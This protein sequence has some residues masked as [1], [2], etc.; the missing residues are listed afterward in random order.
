[1]ATKL[2]LKSQ[3]YQVKEDFS[4]SVDVLVNHGIPNFS[5]VFS[6]NVPEKLRELKTFSLVSVP[7]RNKNVFGIVLSRRSSTDSSLKSIAKVIY[8]SAVLTQEQMNLLHACMNR[9]G[10]FE[11]GR[12]HV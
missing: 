8:P 1:M 11:I 5:N 4:Y 7:F 6:Y 2:R 10:G 12:A 9:W 3:K